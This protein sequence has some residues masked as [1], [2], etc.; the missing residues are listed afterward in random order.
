MNI[1]NKQ[2]IAIFF[3]LFFIVCGISG[4]SPPGYQRNHFDINSIKSYRD[5][6]GI[7]S[8]EIAAIEALRSV[9]TSFSVANLRS[10]EG[11]TQLDGTYAGFI[12]MFCE[13]LSDLFDIQF[14]PEFTSWDFLIKALD[15]KTVDFTTELTPTLERMR[16]YFMTHPVLERLLA[17]FIYSDP[18]KIKNENDLN[19]R[20]VGFYY[21]TITAQSILAMYPSLNFEIVNIQN[22]AH[23]VESLK[24]GFIDVFVADSNVDYVFSA[25]PDIYSKEF[26][27]LVYTPVSLTTANSALSPII[28]VVNKYIEAGGIDKLYEL[29]RRGRKEY[30]KYE[31][32]LSLTAE[33]RAYLDRLVS[34]GSR[35]PVALESDNYPICF[36]NDRD[37]E[38]QGIAVDILEEISL[39]TGIEF[40]VVTD[41]NT[42]WREILEKL[43]RGEASL[44]SELR[45]SEERERYFI[46][47]NHPYATSQY[48]LMSKMDFPNLEIF[49]V[50]RAT[51]GITR[52]TIYDELFRKWFPGNTN[53][54][55]YCTH[56]E[57]IRALERGEVDLLMESEFGLLAQINLRERPGYKANIV[58][59]SPLSESFF[60]FNKSEE[61]LRS[62]IS[63][64]QNQ[65][66]TDSIVRSWTTRVF[67]YSKKYA[68]DRFT[69]MVISTVMLL[70]L[71]VV[72]II[73][74]IKNNQTK[75]LY[76]TEATTLSAMYQSLPDHVYCKDINSV[77]T[78]VN[79]ALE[80]FV[81]R[82]ESE[83]IG[84]TDFDIFEDKIQAQDFVDA[85]KRVFEEKKALKQEILFHQSDGSIR[86]MENIKV[87]L[88]HKGLVTGLLGISRDVTEHKIAN[89]R[90]LIM[91]NATPLIC[92][93]WS[94]EYKVIDCNE[95]ALKMFEMN[96][97]EYM[98]R[99]LELA[100]EFQLDGQRT[101]D[102]ARN[103]LDTTFREG[104]CV[105]E[106]MNQ[107]LDGTLIPMEVT[108]TRVVFG[109]EYVAVGYGRDL[110]KY[111]QLM[112]EI[113]HQNNLLESVNH[114]SSTLLEPNV[115][116]ETA[117]LA[118]MG[119]MAKAVEV[120]RVYV[121]KNHKENGILYG[122]QVYEWSE[123][124]ESQHGRKYTVNVPYFADWE[125]D[126]SRGK[127][128]NGIV[129]NMS[130]EEQERF[131]PQGIVSLIN[132]PIFL[133]DELWG[134]VGFDDCHKERI[135][136]ESEELIL[137]SAS[138]MIANALIRNEMTQNIKITAMQLEIAVK[139]AN[140]ANK[141]KTKSLNT[142][143]SILNGLEA[144]IYVS[145]PDTGEILF[146]ND[147]M[148][149]HYNLEGNCVGQI[150]YK[151]LQKD[152]NEKCDFCPCYQLD[153]DPGETIVWEEKNTLTGRSYRNSDRYIVWPDGRIVHLQ[154]S[155]DITELVV[156]KELAEQG[157]RSKSIFLAKMSHEIRTPMNAIVGMAE[158]ALREKKFDIA[159]SHI[160]TI[161]QAGGNL[162]SIINDILDFSKIESGQMEIIPDYYLFSSLMNDVISIVRM[163]ILDS[164]L[165]F[166]V[167]IDNNIPSELYGDETRIRQILINILNNA[168]KYT[169]DGFVSFTVMGEILEDGII[170]LTIDVMDSG[171]GIKQ[172]D[173]DKL[174]IDFVKLDVA[175]NKSI[176]GTGLG[177][178]IT[179]N[180]LKAMGGDI[181]VF[182]EYGKG[183]TFT[184]TLPQ[185]FRSSESLAVVENPNEKSVIVY[186]RRDIYA[187]SIVVTV[188]SLGVNCE[189]AL[190]ENDFHKKLASKT[191]SFIFIATTLYMNNKK[192][193][194]ELGS[195]SKIV[196]LA[197]FGEAPSNNGWAILAMPVHCISVA[198]ILNGKQEVYS[199]KENALVMDF[200]APD[201]KVLIVDDIRTNL[202]VAEGLLL[203]YNMQ[204][205][206]CKSGIEAIKAV[207]TKQYDLI[208]MDHWMP[209]MDGVEATKRI[210]AFGDRDAYYKNVP[211]IAL[212]ANAVSG[213][214][215]MFMENGFNGFL[216]KPVDTVKLN[217]ILQ[218]WIPK[219]KQKKP[220]LFNDNADSFF[221]TE[222]KKNAPVEIIEIKGV[223]VNKGITLQGGSIDRYWEIL[224]VFYE[225]G[226][227]KVSELKTCMEAED[228]PLYTIHI[229]ALKN[230]AANIGAIELSNNAKALEMAGKQSDLGY[231]KTH[232][233]Q[234]LTDLE[235]ILGYVHDRLLTR[236]KSRE[237]ENNSIDTAELK[238]ILIEL[239]TA[240]EMLDAGM[241]NSAID[242]LLKLKLTE[243]VNVAVR[244]ISKHILITEYDEALA[245]AESLLKEIE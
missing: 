232:A 239:K 193:I 204:V 125:R 152:M 184:I 208:F 90:F 133:Q 70:L 183:S 95:E 41:R 131:S 211:I 98:D 173:M 178:P 196:L 24:S 92:N 127:C 149:Q 87:P 169:S 118:A 150:C 34:S 103:L 145:V 188:D 109:G 23:A 53:A 175:N 242:A 18:E 76:K 166:A 180:L 167:S 107:K 194:S 14:L 30:A 202:K 200:Q 84:K 20:R 86:F 230:A 115:E 186:E 182:S 134:V 212:T 55:H 78:R 108:L 153:K 160:F 71:L 13:L 170:N 6:P 111:K 220:A 244:S 91:L 60:G 198:N 185:K 147:Y 27:Q 157:N 101:T 100:P 31:F 126:L 129:R 110:R 206:L 68:E 191:Y 245:L 83:M 75:M 218:E 137:R 42:S 151:V 25:Y 223:D 3:A 106:W 225:D 192:I 179:W 72:L 16:R 4:C 121:W 50:V 21:G 161:K 22:T 58:F 119:M 89:E 164:Q 99:F 141:I 171:K 237:G 9:R 234:F 238:T 45:Y 29:Y 231:I 17:I 26:F 28:S 168:V 59:S 216:A 128:L 39:L 38:F 205:D 114:V 43:R 7:T 235:L 209:E 163:R 140:E 217:K 120:D 201:A 228:I 82:P 88:M 130:Q 195:S 67:D 63:K 203:P 79:Q 64:A 135:F 19:G 85:D 229:H 80:E 233:S 124:V 54:R 15:D 226:L 49:Q 138:R 117:L 123:S 69:Y 144:M 227:E 8:E 199:Y 116:F 122:T 57:A 197:E 174:F 158:L 221:V 146:V 176:E 222:D 236:N 112:E 156:A 215:D 94:K 66:R 210:R 190:T 165:R 10:T 40:D 44:V 181:K 5:I 35:I 52:E 177:L 240:I 73:L 11:F 33:E 219:E 65:I 74:L 213:T 97:K 48:I 56:G 104:K 93:L 155:V 47:A 224:E 102:K 142:L 159:Q 77:Y 1:A 154:Y 37:G 132:V 162:L 189:L 172:E 243:D 207:R 51:V 143:E 12:I 2:V 139:E 214:R 136:T 81:K 113:D 46:W 187:N 61:L 105:F 241:I 36:F 96:K 32:S 62:I 148:K